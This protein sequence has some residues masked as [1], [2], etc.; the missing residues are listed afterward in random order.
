MAVPKSRTSKSRKRMRRANYKLDTPA[1]STC[2]KCGETKLPHRVCKKC[3]T[4][5]NVE[6]LKIEQ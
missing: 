5:N 1:L 3:G 6:V 4:Y 2:P